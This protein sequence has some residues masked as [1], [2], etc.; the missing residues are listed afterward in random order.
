MPKWEDYRIRGGDE[1]EIESVYHV[2]YL[3]V[4]KRIVEDGQVNS[5]LIYDRSLLNRS[6]ISVA[7]LSANTWAQ[8]SLYGTVSFAFP[9]AEIIKDQNIY[10]VEAITDYSPTAF[11][12]LLTKRDKPSRHLQ[13][14][15]PERDNGPL[16]LRDGKWLRA[17]H[18]TS[19]F[20][21][22]EDLSLDR[23]IELDFISHHHTYCNL[24]GGACEE[25]RRQ[26]RPQKTA[27]SMLAHTLARNDHS[28]DR[29]WKP[30]GVRAV[31]TPLETG[32]SGLLTE[33]GGR[34]T[35]FGGALRRPES[36]GEALMGA[37][38]LYSLNRI[39]EARKLLSLVSSFEHLE[40]A[41]L[42]VVR[43]HFKDSRWRPEF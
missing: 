29:L 23:S 6:R 35:D 5:G 14:Y 41:L 38:S 22:E 11:R 3:P 20:M 4:G 21:I 18:L 1:R 42:K 40:R 15:D 30:A 39:P 9:W 16:R 19:E 31:F 12:F 2:A 25:L 17:G 13:P 7:W 43:R 24:N 8:G 32:Y 33:L 36:C 34:K 37:L 10:W 27:A 28:I 26:P